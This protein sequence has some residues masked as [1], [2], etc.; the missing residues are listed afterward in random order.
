MLGVFLKEQNGSISVIMVNK[1][2]GRS[3]DYLVAEGQM[4]QAGLYPPLSWS[5]GRI[6]CLRVH[7]FE[8][9]IG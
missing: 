2:P 7:C 1:E 4:L 6:T 9:R 3:N 8:V 5:S